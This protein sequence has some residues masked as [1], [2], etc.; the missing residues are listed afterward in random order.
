[1]KGN[2]NYQAKLRNKRYKILDRFKRIK[3]C[4]NCGFNNADALQ[5]DH[6]RDKIA[7]VTTMVAQTAPWKRIKNEVSKCQILCANCHQIKTKRERKI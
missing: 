7:N 4:N 3:G 1:M 6:L 5:F 2:M